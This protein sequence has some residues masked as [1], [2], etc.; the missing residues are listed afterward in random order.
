MSRNIAQGCQLLRTGGLC[1]QTLTPGSMRENGARAYDYWQL[2]GGVDSEI[3]QMIGGN[4]EDHRRDL[5]I[6]VLC[7]RSG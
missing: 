7:V 2:L 5:S 4:H 1:T 3:P 6:V